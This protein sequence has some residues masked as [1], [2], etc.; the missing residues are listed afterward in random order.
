M[1]K[2]HPEMG[3]NRLK[4]HFFGQFWVFFG[5]VFGVFLISGNFGIFSGDFG[6]FLGNIYFSRIFWVILGYFW[7][8][9]KIP[10]KLG[11]AFSAPLCVFESPFN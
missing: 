5:W 8:T 11:S 6:Y 7:C 9:L 3:D 1:G 4:L 2:N 10:Q